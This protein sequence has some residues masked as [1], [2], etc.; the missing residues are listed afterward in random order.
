MMVDER[1]QDGTDLVKNGKVLLERGESGRMLLREGDLDRGGSSALF[2]LEM[3]ENC[4]SK[5]RLPIVNGYQI[6]ATTGI[7]MELVTDGGC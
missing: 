3:L 5:I 4:C 2:L 7:H 1:F 6:Y